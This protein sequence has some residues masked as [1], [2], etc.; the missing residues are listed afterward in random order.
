[1]SFFAPTFPTLLF[2]LEC[3]FINKK[4]NL[5]ILIYIT[6]L[7]KKIQDSLIP[8]NLV[9]Y[10]TKHLYHHIKHIIFYVWLKYGAILIN[11]ASFVESFSIVMCSGTRFLNHLSRHLKT[12]FNHPNHKKSPPFQSRSMWVFNDFFILKT[13]FHKRNGDSK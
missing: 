5:I 2:N 4:I 11:I 1:M 3:Y 10:H 12:C 13:I 9:I 6:F 8:Q 7:M